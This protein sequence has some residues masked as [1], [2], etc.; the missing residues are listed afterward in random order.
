MMTQCS[1]RLITPSLPSRLQMKIRMMFPSRP[2]SLPPDSSQLGNGTEKQEADSDAE[3]L[4]QLLADASI[5]TDDVD[6]LTPLLANPA[7]PGVGSDFGGI[8]HQ[9]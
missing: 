6:L 4:M 8:L 1:R 5:N 3:Y 2:P 7:V 9:N